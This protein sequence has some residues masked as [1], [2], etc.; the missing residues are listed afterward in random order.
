MY[1]E[2]KYQISLAVVDQLLNPEEL[3]DVRDV[4]LT[5]VRNLRKI[6]MSSFYSKYQ[7]QDR[8]T[9][10]TAAG[11]MRERGASKARVSAEAQSC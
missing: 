11:G 5:W 10:C 8:R 7:V 2:F 4:K 6:S 9:T 3:Q 1:F